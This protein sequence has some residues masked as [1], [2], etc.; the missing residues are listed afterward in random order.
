M[1]RFDLSLDL[2]GIGDDGL[3][4]G[5]AAGY[6]DVDLGGDIIIPGALTKSIATRSRVPMLLFHDQK[7]PVG[8][9]DTMRERGDALEVKGRFA[10]STAAGREAHALTKDGAL[11]GLSIGY[12]TLRHRMA[13]KAR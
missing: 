3:I 12:R 4:E 13:G 7:R 11:P 9:W 1:E 6:G 8:V 10:M 5:V 2:K